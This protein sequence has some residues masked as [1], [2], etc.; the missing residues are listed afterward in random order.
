M[1][2]D[3]LPLI[4]LLAVVLAAVLWRDIARARRDARRAAEAP[5]AKPH[6]KPQVKPQTNKLN[7][8][9]MKLPAKPADQPQTSFRPE[10]LVDGSNVMHWQDN[11]A[12]LDTLRMVVDEIVLMGYRP[13]VIFDASAG[14]KLFGR[15]RDD[16]FMAQALGL[17]AVQVLVVPKGEPA[18]RF[19]LAVSRL[20]S[21]PIVTNDRYRGWLAEFPEV[22]QPGR[23]LRGGFREGRVWLNLDD[24]AG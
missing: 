3:V 7:K 17:D 23:L 9:L 21:A 15:Y 2:S 8:Q 10:V 4:V 20:R 6:A 13:G 16:W 11:L 22:A 5:P 18:D 24:F 1:I 14:Y 19:L 12:Q